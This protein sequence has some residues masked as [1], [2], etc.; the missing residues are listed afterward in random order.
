MKKLI[1]CFVVIVLTKVLFATEFSVYE[2]N[3][4]N[5][6]DYNVNIDEAALVVHP[7]GNFVEM[8][9]YVT[10]SYDFESWFFKNYNELEF[11]WKFSL[12]EHAIMHE[13][14]IWFGDSIMSA[15]VLDKWTAE[16]IF[17]D[18]SSPIRNPGL[19]TQSKAN[20][21]GQVEYNLRLFPIKRDEQK[22]FK[23]QY[24]LPGRPS[25]EAMRAWL[26]T[27]QLF[28][29][30]SKNIDQLRIIYKYY[31]APYEPTIVGTDVLSS[32]SSPKDS[33]WVIGIPLEYDQFVELILPSPIRNQFYFSQYKYN[34]ENFYHLAVY[35]PEESGA[36]KKP[37][38]ILIVVDFNRMNTDGLDGEFLLSYLKETIQQAFSELE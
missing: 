37:R 3:Y 1:I 34:G 36:E 8:N 15:E 4:P 18:V 9:L 7:R 17:S 27:T 19:L 12:P 13:F 35:P 5:V 20:R 30:K 38:N 26:P 22:R 6:K 21:D 16:L 10:V 2:A 29:E 25:V 24:L 28:S 23:I 33:A 31:D 14:W 32:I 11:L